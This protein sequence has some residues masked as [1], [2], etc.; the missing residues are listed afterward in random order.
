MSWRNRTAVTTSSFVPVS[1][2][3]RWPGFLV[4]ILEVLSDGKVW[5]KKD[6]EEAVLD[7]ARITQEQRL[8]QLGSG[9]G[10]ALNRVGW[11]LSF[12]TRAEVITKPAR[13][14]FQILEEGRHLLAEN[15]SGITEAHLKR[16]P[17]FLEYVPTRGKGT[18]GIEEAE[19]AIDEDEDPLEQIEAGISKFENDVA[20]ELIRRLHEQH[21][22]FFEQAVVDLLKAM[23]YG[24]AESRV[25]RLGRSG[26]GG[27]D[28]VIDQDALGLSRVYIQAK[29]YAPGNMVHRPD[30]QGFVGA[31]ASKGATQ[32]VF[33]TTS[34]F[35]S[36]AR[37]YVEQIP[38]RV[39]L[40]DGI[41]LAELMIHYQVGVQ[42]KRTFAVVEVDADYFE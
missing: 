39:V 32:G 18:A 37:E 1:A 16:V 4:P 5:K 36:G 7:K 13:A 24:G 8:E 38:S 20:A 25:T 23:G 29:R 17:A 33:V 12:L 27:V 31:L 22:D 11:A 21:P 35:S 15:P 6:L 34:G 42:V 28:G 14:Q 30:L 10:R 9:D 41:R 19:Q 40:I 2:I 26:D 3:P